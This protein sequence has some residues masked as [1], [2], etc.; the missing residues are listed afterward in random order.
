MAKAMVE[1]NYILSEDE[2]HP[3]M[4]SDFWVKT[5]FSASLEIEKAKPKRIVKKD[6]VPVTH[7]LK[8]GNLIL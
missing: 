5:T 3:T 7:A 8:I 1:A 2:K 6:E 4:I